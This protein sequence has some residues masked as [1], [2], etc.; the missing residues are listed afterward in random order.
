MT[1]LVHINDRQR[2]Q[3]VKHIG[4]ISITIREDVD[5]VARVIAEKRQRALIERQNSKHESDICSAPHS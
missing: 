3:R 1:A 5:L 4:S 2:E